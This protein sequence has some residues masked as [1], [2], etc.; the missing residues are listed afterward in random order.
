MGP[1]GARSGV[2]MGPKGLGSAL[3]CHQLAL[4]PLP[5]RKSG[6]LSLA[7]SPRSAKT[8]LSKGKKLAKVKSKVATKQVRGSSQ[9][10]ALAWASPVPLTHPELPVPTVQGPGGQQA[11]GELH[12]GG[13]L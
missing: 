5:Q 13:R 7:L 10:P 12:R 9:A 6:A 3:Q 2:A 4:S 8:I 1:W 11:A